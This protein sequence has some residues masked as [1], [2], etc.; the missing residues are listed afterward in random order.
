MN[1]DAESTKDD[2][3]IVMVS[4]IPR[5]DECALPY[6]PLIHSGIFFDLSVCG[7]VLHISECPTLLNQPTVQVFAREVTYSERSPISINAARGAINFS[8]CDVGR[9]VITDVDAASPLI[10]FR[11]KANLIGLGGVYSLEANFSRADSK[12]IAVNNSGDAR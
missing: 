6:A 8:T 9:E 11:V 12:R 4:P 10:T 2:S 1:R 7:R 5:R 3:L